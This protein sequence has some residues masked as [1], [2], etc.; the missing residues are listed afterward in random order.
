MENVHGISVSGGSFP[1]EIWR[2]MMETHDRA[3][4]GQ[5]LRRAEGV[6]RS[7][8]RSSVARSRSATTRTTSPA[9]HRDD[10]HHG[11]RPT[12]RPTRPATT[13]ATLHTRRDD[14][15]AVRRS[16]RGPGGRRHPRARRR[17][18]ARS[19]GGPTRR[20]CRGNGGNVS[21]VRRRSS[22]SLLL[23]RVRRLSRRARSRSAARAP[24][25][26]G[27]RSCSPPRSSS[28]RSRR[29]CLLSTDAW[30][31]WSYGWIGARGD[32]NPY[33]D[34]P[35]DVPRP[36]RRSR[37]WGAPG[38][39]T[40][41]VYG[42]AFTIAS[43]PLAL[44]AGDSDDVAAW[45]YKAL[46]AGG[47]TRRGAARR[48]AR[49]PAG[50]R[51]RARRLEPAPR[52]APRRRRPQRRLGRRADPRCARAL[53]VPAAAGRRAPCG[54]SRSP[55]SGCR[56]AL[57]RAPRRSRLARPRTGGGYHRGF[58]LTAAAIVVG[59]TR[60]L[61]RRLAARDLPARRQRGARDELRDPA[62]ARAA[63]RAR[64]GRARPRRRG[65]S[66]A[67]SPGSRAK[68]AAGGLD[69]VSPPA[70]CS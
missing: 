37:T 61:R 7:T 21:G 38:V 16:P 56:I 9:D 33:A 63:R 45:T 52:R 14:E 69:S 35:Q 42:P 20:S 34:P 36:T 5:G 22:S 43:E 23:A 8:S 11:R 48:P 17:R 3:A 10:R 59:A 15:T 47:V 62:P 49:P 31:Y 2:L 32:G 41:S 51:D 24:S 64:R 40:T 65:A 67:A 19:P 39:D 46:A 18:P 60:A 54:C 44:V 1:A 12:P 25:H 30:T 13:T 53:G 57:P 27:R 4:A 66:S 6:S 26:P 28:C 68:P 29:R 58:A 55:S 50:V 70:S